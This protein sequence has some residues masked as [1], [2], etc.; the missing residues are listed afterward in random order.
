MLNEDNKKQI[1]HALIMTRLTGN[2]LC[3]FKALYHTAYRWVPYGELNLAVG[4]PGGPGQ[5]NT[6]IAQVIGRCGLW[7]GVIQGNEEK[8]PQGLFLLKNE[9]VR[10]DKSFQLTPEFR[11][12]IGSCKK[13]LNFLDLSDEHLR[14]EFPQSKLLG[15]SEE[16]FSELSGTRIHTVPKDIAPAIVKK[17]IELRAMEVVA[18]YY[19]QRG[20]SVED[21]SKSNPEGSGA[22]F[23][24]LITKGEY[25]K[26][27]EVKGT[28]TR[29]EHVTLTAN[30]VLHAREHSAQSVLVVVSGIN[31]RLLNGYVQGEDGQITYHKDP[32][33]PEKN[34][35]TPTQYRYDIR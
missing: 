25:K 5:D 16:D 22:P 7:D 24:F 34:R 21:T 9:P 14:E 28:S 29:R 19:K 26:Y 12:C 3:V 30:E 11:S 15:L 31:T 33:C 20:W 35:L 8:L 32:W 27:V 10:S 17:A 23:D 4:Y 18:S 6:R 2:I 1:Q 13:I